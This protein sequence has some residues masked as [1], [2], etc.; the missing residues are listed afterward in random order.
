LSIRYR[1]ATASD[2]SAIAALVKESYAHYVPLIGLRPAP[3]DADYAVVVE[4]QAVWVA[5]GENGSPV[6]VVVLGLE[7][8]HLVVDNVAVAPGSQGLGVGT[9]LL[10]I[11][12]SEA[13]EAGR[14]EVRLFTH[15]MMTDNIAYYGRR[16][17]LETHRLTERGF[18]RA[19]F[20]KRLDGG[21]TPQ[22]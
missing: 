21:A 7:A 15:V 5:V 6:G 22:R 14:T 16:G 3:M 18:S 13:K 17:Y 20:S 19:F 9:R 1:R 10:D 11:A 8:D 4:R 2:A 12:E